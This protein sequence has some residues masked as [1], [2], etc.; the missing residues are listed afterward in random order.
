MGKHKSSV[1][2]DIGA[3]AEAK[4][5]VRADV[6]ATSVGR[7]FDAFTDLIRP[8]SEP[9]GLR[10]DLVRLQR[11][12]VAIEIA[13]RARERIRI[14]QGN[15]Q[16]VPTK[17]LVPLIEKGSCEDIRDEGMIDRWANLLASAS[18]QLS[19]QP[20][21]VSILEELSGSQAECLEY[22]AFHEF[23]QFKLPYAC[24][25]NAPYIYAEH[26]AKQELRDLVTKNLRS[27]KDLQKTLD[28]IFEYLVSPG[29]FI[30]LVT[31]RECRKNGKWASYDTVHAT[32]IRRED[33][34]AILESLGLIR[35]VVIDVDVNAP[36]ER[37]ADLE[38]SVY[39]YHLTT[40]GFGFCEVCSRP[41]VLKLEQIDKAN[42]TSLDDD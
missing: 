16:A 12:E 32:G 23:E 26:F 35:K 6:P 24:V 25:S 14:E 17:L 33:D 10:A 21:F 15:P 20:R 38:A 13:K 5:V 39:Y 1:K 11:E 36:S 28:A 27:K 34:L 2:V 7:L 8:F 9:R 22:V 3:R 41:T 30:E 42:T 29:V 31:V 4:L 37:A 19:V 40:L 18:L